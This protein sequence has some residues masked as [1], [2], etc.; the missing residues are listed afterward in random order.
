MWHFN[1]SGINLKTGSIHQKILG[2][3]AKRLLHDQ[4]DKSNGHRIVMKDSALSLDQA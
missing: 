4:P 2:H 1:R 3:L